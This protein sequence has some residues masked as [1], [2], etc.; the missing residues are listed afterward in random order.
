MIC[1]VIAKKAESFHLCWWHQTGQGGWA[2]KFVVFLVQSPISRRIYLSARCSLEHIISSCTWKEGRR[3]LRYIS[4][5]PSSHSYAAVPIWDS[6]LG[7]REAKVCSQCEARQQNGRAAACPTVHVLPRLELKKSTRF[8]GK[9][10]CQISPFSV[11]IS[12]EASLII[13][14]LVKRK[15]QG[16]WQRQEIFWQDNRNRAM[17][18]SSSCDSLGQGNWRNLIQ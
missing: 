14:L 13:K 11:N 1:W 10:K 4:G 18:E 16:G 8:W 6:W 7:S 3:S 5:T 2:L 9:S 17:L 15:R 12:L